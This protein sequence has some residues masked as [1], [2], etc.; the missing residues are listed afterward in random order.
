[1]VLK[2]TKNS[3]CSKL[4]KMLIAIFVITIMPLY[5]QE[6]VK[7]LSD[8]VE[9][10]ILKP[11]KND[12]AYIKLQVVTDDIIHVSACPVAAFDATK[13]LMLSDTQPAVVKFTTKNSNDLVIVS[14]KNL[15]AVVS[16]VT[17]EVVFKDKS[18]RILLQE[19]ANGGKTF[20]C[21]TLEGEQSYGIRQSFTSE[22]DEAFYGLGQHQNGAFN[23]KG[24][25]VLLSQYNTEVGVPFLI[26]SKNYGIL[27]DNNSI[28]KSV[29]THDYEKLSTLKLFS[30]KGE[31]GWLTATYYD[32]NNPEKVI[33]SRPESYIDYSYIPS[34]KNLPD[35][36]NLQNTLVKWEG[37]IESGFTGEHQ[38]NLWYSGYIK[39]YIDDKPVA[40]RWRQGWN[41]STHLIKLNLEKG[42]KYKIK[43]DWDPVST[44]SFLALNWFKPLTK[45][46]RNEFAF[47]SEAG[48]KIDYYF[49]SGNSMDKVISGYRQ[50]TG[51]ATLLPKWTMGFWQSRER[52]NNQEEILSTVA[53]FRKRKIGLD[54]IVLDWRYWKEGQWGTQQFDTDRFPDAAG[55]TKTL[56]D[57][58]HTNFMISVWAKFY[59]NT[60]NY[61]DLKSKGFMLT[62][63]VAD[64]RL[65]WLGFKNGIYDAYNPEARKAFWRLLDTNL[66]NKG[67]DAWWMDASEPDIHSNMPP[68][69]RKEMI[70]HNYLGAPEKNYNAFSLVNAQGIY[71]GQRSTD[72]NKRVFILTRSGFAGLQR[73][74]AATWSGD[75]GSRW[76]DL[77]NQIPAGLNFSM[78]GLPYWAT[79]IGGFSVEQRYEKATGETLEEWRELNARWHQY[80]VFCPLFRAHGQFPYREIYNIAPDDHPAYKSILYYNKLRYRL[81]PYIYSL[82]GKVYHEDYT[83]M[84][85]LPMDFGTDKKVLDIADQF[86][87]GPSILVNPVTEYKKRSREVYLP[88]TNGWYDF[89][90]SEFTEGGKTITAQAIY[91]RVPLYIKEGSVLIAG[92]NIE[93]TSQ[94]SAEPL[95]VYVYTGKDAS[96][97]L[98][99]DEGI[100]YNYE[101]G[102]FATIDFNYNEATKTLTVSDRKGSFKGMEKNR[103]FNIVFV[104]KTKKAV[105][106]LLSDGKYD[107]QIKYSGKRAEVKL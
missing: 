89:Y 37:S 73:Y 72:A 13:S 95:T 98:Y 64:G 75:I 38:F 33:I 84:R 58:Y 43:I 6:G 56:H 19:T 39:L 29:D 31:Q 66:F 10:K 100:N 14:T 101:K 49:I 16:K 79:D 47:E 18:G 11:A 36:I 86:M 48:Q 21:T 15:D 104:S 42:K 74:A 22:D 60:Q 70:G 54:N 94:K 44:E 81:M 106:N 51:K 78:S 103:F 96:F 1:M 3:M 67:I 32:K 26:S 23:Y 69:V 92:A 25:K 83:M 5:A 107:K 93:Y 2:N 82:A 88:N 35:G 97:T 28:T 17:G 4:Q 40:D 76:E 45:E 99:E 20:T 87:F 50:L 53:E 105:F 85:G 102:Q 52:Y 91:E 46:L 90:T 27:W 71:E 80:G 55:M 9:I 62:R 24:T 59:E 34:L 77:Q 68:D 63:N 12:A 57:K 41:A 65:D 30:D 8:G 7:S 61:Q